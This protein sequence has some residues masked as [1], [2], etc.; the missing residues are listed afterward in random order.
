MGKKKTNHQW[1]RVFGP[2][3]Q[4]QHAE[5]G[6]KNRAV[7]ELTKFKRACD[8]AGIEPTI[9]QAS[10]FRKKRGLAFTSLYAA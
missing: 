2:N 6:K 3:L 5:E 9:R 8:L 1:I 7:F 10:K 4:P